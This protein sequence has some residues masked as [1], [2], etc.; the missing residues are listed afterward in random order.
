[1]Q[2]A[3][4]LLSS[5]FLLGQIHVFLS[6]KLTDTRFILIAQF[7]FF[8]RFCTQRFFFKRISICH[9]SSHSAS[10]SILLI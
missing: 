5:H 10:I 7:Y 2:S 9:E 4:F 6:A 3:I 1:M 8:N